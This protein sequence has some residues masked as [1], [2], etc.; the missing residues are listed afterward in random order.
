MMEEKRKMN[1]AQ[2][3]KGGG[4]GNKNKKGKKNQDSDS[5][6]DCDDYDD[7]ESDCSEYSYSDWENPDQDNENMISDDDEDWNG[8]KKK[9]RR[10]RNKNVW[11]DEDGR[12]YRCAGRLLLED[13]LKDTENFEGWSAARVQAWKNKEHNPNAYYYRFNAPGE[14]QK[15]GPVMMDEHKNFMERVMEVG[16]NMHWGKFSMKIP[17]RVG[18]QC[19]NY[20]RQMM[21]DQWVKDPN[22]WIRAD[23]SFAFK[24][25][26]KGS[27]PDAIRKYSFV[28]LKDPSKV[29][30]SPGY[31]P[32][33]PS[34]KQLKKYLED[35]VRDIVNKK[36]GG[37]GGKKKARTTKNS[38]KNDGGDDKKEDDGEEKKAKTVRSK[39]NKK[40]KDPNKPKNPLSSYLL[41]CNEVRAKFTE[42]NKGQSMGKISKLISAEWK[43]LSEAD[44]KPYVDESVKLRAK[45]KEE[46]E[47]YK[48]SDK[49]TEYMEILK[50]WNEDQVKDEGEEEDKDKKEEKEADDDKV[51][52]VPEDKHDSDK[53]NKDP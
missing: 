47:E 23:G 44:K 46:M 31:H 26:K 37:K 36:K 41:Y 30:D 48:K 34:D 27:V 3:G 4:G 29:F 20:W 53:E 19:S 18:Y 28:V 35:G 32:K 13:A 42:E 51:A 5:E 8:G 52:V 10:R 40:P 43:A 17:G 7:S 25:A 22:Y 12:E 6:F 24:R 15:N 45:W 16:V 50:K 38:T 11:R 2:N 49:Y 9:K 21:K 1:Q 39:S 33:R 14:K